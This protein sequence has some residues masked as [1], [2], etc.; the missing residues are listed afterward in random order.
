MTDIQAA[1]GIQQLK[2]LPAFQV[3]R[4]EIVRRYSEAFASLPELRVPAE[5]HEVQHAWH[6]YALRLNLAGLAI[7]RSRFIEE[8]K[9]RNIGASVHFIPNHLQPYYR[10]KYGYKPQ[11]FPVASAEFQ[12]LVSLPLYP[13]MSDQDVTDVIDAVTA[14][15]QSNRRPVFHIPAVKTQF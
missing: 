8:L 13:R 2:K 10:D 15:V 14:V 12:R 5:H 4:R 3:R 7:D 1:I 11:D 6:I 9:A